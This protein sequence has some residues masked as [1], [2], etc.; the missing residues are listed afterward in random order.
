VLAQY[1]GISGARAE[2]IRH[3]VTLALEGNTSIAGS[4]WQLFGIPAVWCCAYVVFNKGSSGL[5][6]LAFAA[7]AV[8]IISGAL[9]IY[10]SR[11]DTLLGLIGIWVVYFYSGR[12]VPGRVILL[13]VPAMV[14]LSQPILSE[15]Q[16]LSHTAPI[17]TV[18][19]VSRVTSYGVLDFSLAIHNEPRT[20]REQ[21]TAP[22]RWL[23]LPAY[24]VPSGLW[25]GRPNLA[26]RRLGLYTAQDFGTVNDKATGFPT[27]YVTEGWLLGGWPG[28][29][30]L[31]ILFGSALGWVSRRLTRDLPPSP[32][33]VLT[34]AFVVTL[35]WTYYK[36]G[37]LLATIVGEGRTAVYLGILM[38]ITGVVGH[39]RRW[40]T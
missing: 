20:I 28:A 9:V 12:R 25:H 6:R 16:G 35:G 18:E 8:L 37:D 34:L 27:T 5:V 19:S 36:D 4:A 7:S 32:A 39:R 21:I 3:T 11:L 15:R 29:I 2:F 38:W 30:I 26:A 14:L 17:S 23:D 10:G 13:V 31:S 24:F 22:N 40:R 33:A 1:G